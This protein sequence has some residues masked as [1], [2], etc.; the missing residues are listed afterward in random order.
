MNNSSEKI[1]NSGVAVILIAL[2]CFGY[3]LY[4]FKYGLNLSDEGYLVYGAKRVLNGQI[5]GVDFHAYMPGRYL[6]LAA[7]ARS[8]ANNSFMGSVMIRSRQISIPGPNW[9]SVKSTMPSPG[10]EL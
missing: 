2:F 9:S 3:Y 6:V 4:Y 5:P 8:P 10:K 1:Q 7:S